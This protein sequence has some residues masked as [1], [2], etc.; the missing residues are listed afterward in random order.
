MRR[1][2]VPVLAVAAALLLWL[3]SVSAEEAS[4]DGESVAQDTQDTK[5][6]C[7]EEEAK[8]DTDWFPGSLSGNATIITDY[9]FRGVSQTDRGFA[10][11][12]GIDWAHDS[13]VFLGIWGS[14][15][16]FGDAYLESDFYGGY[17]NSI[18]DFTYKIWITGF[19][20]PQD[21]QFN[22]VEFA[23]RGDYDF[24]VAS[25]NVG[26]V[27]SND[28]FGTLGTGFYVPFGFAVPIPEDIKYFD[29][30]VDAN[31]GYTS[32][33]Q[34]IFEDGHY[35]DWNAGLV[36]SLP[37]GLSFN[38]RYVDTDVKNVHDAGARFVFGTT[39][40]FGG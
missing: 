34:D 27:G 29:L 31:A 24:G 2:K 18:S 14:P 38:F 8:D 4:K 16:H 15:V 13:G 6:A 19:V 25:A 32:T 23:A 21:S 12:G 3:P 35:W 39:Y 1:I 33:Q 37:V 5:A 10:Y 9:S 26:L 40:A 7:A 30:S 28:Y 20:Y 17:S 22:Y 11:Q 36:V